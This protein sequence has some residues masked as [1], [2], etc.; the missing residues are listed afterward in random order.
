MCVCGGGGGGGDNYLQL[1]PGEAIFLAPNEPHAYLYGG[2]GVC[3]CVCVVGGGGGGG[4]YGMN[5]SS[6]VSSSMLIC[7]EVRMIS[8]D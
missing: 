1:Q 7:M 4:T 8:V 6:I 2:E 5:S 3:V